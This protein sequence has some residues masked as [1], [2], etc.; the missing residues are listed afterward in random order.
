M[1]AIAY[2]NTSHSNLFVVRTRWVISGIFSL[3]GCVNRLSCNWSVVNLISLESISAARWLL[4]LIV[5]DAHVD[6]EADDEEHADAEQ[7]D[8][9]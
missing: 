1:F 8:H 4:Q 5:Q 3:D 7:D 9:G 2:D 6:G